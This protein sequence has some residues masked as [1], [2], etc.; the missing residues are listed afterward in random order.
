MVSDASRMPSVTL[1][2]I[3]GA[4]HHPMTVVRGT[5]MP[6]PAIRKQNWRCLAGSRSGIWWKW[7]RE[8]VD[9]K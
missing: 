8:S 6:T 9:A 1:C 7:C 2:P 3:S 4:Q 5:Q